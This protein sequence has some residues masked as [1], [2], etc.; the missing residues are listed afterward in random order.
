MATM[1]ALSGFATS[2]WA[3]SV[4]ETTTSSDAAPAQVT[5]SSV[6]TTGTVSDFGDSDFA[7]RASAEAAPVHYYFTKTTRYV[8]TD[9]NTV[10]ASVIH[11]GV[12]V[13]VEYARIGDRLVASRVIVKRTHVET[14]GGDAVESH[15]TTTSEA[16]APTI[17]TKKTT[18]TTTSNGE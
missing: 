5:T 18:T 9:G 2:A 10:S 12:P 15:T 8:D 6:T 3:Q 7:I 1:G 17:T 13:T 11:S 16:P 4:T 14:T